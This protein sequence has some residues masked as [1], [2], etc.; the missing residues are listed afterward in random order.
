MLQ[1]AALN[2][3]LSWFEIDVLISTMLHPWR[4]FLLSKNTCKGDKLLLK[5][6]RVP[7]RRVYCE[8]RAEGDTIYAFK[9]TPHV[10]INV[11]LRDM[12]VKYDLFGWFSEIFNQKE[13]HQP[14]F[15]K[16]KKIVLLG[17]AG[18]EFSFC[19]PFFFLFWAWRLKTTF[20]SES[21]SWWCCNTSC[22]YASQS[23]EH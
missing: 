15:W 4:T 1:N 21:Q 6:M 10:F 22:K 14:F 5:R 13:L 19:L 23:W 11:V 3:V 18:S 8:C 12:P 9:V 16:Y 17:T 7:A 2:S 20:G